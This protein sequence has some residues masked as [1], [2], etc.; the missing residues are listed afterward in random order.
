MASP[1]VHARLIGV[2]VGIGIGVENSVDQFPIP[3][4]MAT[5]TPMDI[6]IS[7]FYEAIIHER[8]AVGSGCVAFLLSERFSLILKN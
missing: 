2:G 6:V 1:K 7:T 5:P 4:L 8:F 3:I